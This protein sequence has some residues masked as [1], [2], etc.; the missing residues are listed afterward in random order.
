[1]VLGI[2]VGRKDQP[3]ATHSDALAQGAALD[4]RFFGTFMKICSGHSSTMLSESHWQQVSGIHY[5]D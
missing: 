1:M 5:L 2:G 3:A 4:D